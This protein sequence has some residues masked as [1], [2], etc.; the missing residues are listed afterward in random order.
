[1]L[2]A[3]L[4]AESF[5][6]IRVIDRTNCH[7]YIRTLDQHF[8]L[9][10]EIFVK[11]RGWKDFERN[12]I[13]EKDQYDNDN[14]TYLIS[15]DD[16]ENVV[17]SFRLYP[18]VLPHMLSEQF[19]ALIEGAVLQRIDI[20]EMTRLAICRNQRGTHTYFELFLALQE[21][22]L[23]QGVS[24]A[25]NLVR[26]HRIPVVQKAGMNIT[27]LGLSREIGGEMCT[28]ALLEISEEILKR[29]RKVAGITETVMEDRMRP[30]R[31][32]A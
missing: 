26:T 12:G 8:R 29:M 19:S 5:K 1:M 32:I 15:I 18:T 17:G 3:F 30:V 7:Q 21:Y 13:Y 10:H 22:C 28:P 2:I 9:R 31:K 23:E 25:T 27:P 24:G 6:M 20:L 4:N 16:Q 14:A 11:E